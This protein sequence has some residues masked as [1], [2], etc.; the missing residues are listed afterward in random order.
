MTTAI[1]LSR[2]NDAD[3]SAQKIIALEVVKSSS[4]FSLEGPS[5]AHRTRN[6]NNVCVQ[7][8]EYY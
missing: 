4:L 7:A 1:T 6:E 2:Q 8:K 5:S 3:S